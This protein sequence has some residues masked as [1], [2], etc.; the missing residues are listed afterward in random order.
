[1][2]ST[3]WLYFRGNLWTVTDLIAGSVR[4]RI[5]KSSLGLVHELKMINSHLLQGLTQLLESQDCRLAEWLRASISDYDDQRSP[6]FLS[7]HSRLHDWTSLFFLALAF[8]IEISGR[9]FLRLLFLLLLLFSQSY[10]P[11]SYS[12]ISI[13]GGAAALL[14]FEISSSLKNILAGFKKRHL[15]KERE[16]ERRW[17][18]MQLVLFCVCKCDN[19]LSTSSI[20]ASECACV[21]YFCASSSVTYE[22]VLIRLFRG[23]KVGTIKG[24]WEKPN[25]SLFTIWSRWRSTL[26]RRNVETVLELWFLKN[27]LKDGVI[28]SG[29]PIDIEVS[30]VK[31]TLYFFLNG[32]SVLGGF[33]LLFI[34]NGWLLQQSATVSLNFVK[35]FGFR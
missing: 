17:I 1:M 25:P 20:L 33:P 7:L 12:S 14:Y 2:L 6:F 30:L 28:E 15:K 27:G 34:L 31:V 10:L 35:T 26:N 5:T 8:S 18:S 9:I 23:K 11:S 16:K 19:F 4:R 32:N 13:C 3:Y 21:R 24:E 29:T 22:R